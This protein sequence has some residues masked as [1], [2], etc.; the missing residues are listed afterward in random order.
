MIDVTAVTAIAVAG[1]V[2]LGAPAIAAHFQRIRDKERFDEERRARDVA[3]LRARLEDVAGAFD[4]AARSAS[5]LLRSFLEQGVRYDGL[6]HLLDGAYADL[7]AARLAMARLGLWLP[8]EAG[9]RR[10]AADGVAAM[11]RAVHDIAA[12]RLFG[13][14]PPDEIKERM[15]ADGETWGEEG[16][17]FLDEARALAGPVSIERA[18][19]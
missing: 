11:E 18:L 13:D 8:V 19:T 4:Q 9:P 17:H 10:A 7:Q 3:E 2:G 12:A 1:L 16:I 14:E 15:A 6:T 5:L